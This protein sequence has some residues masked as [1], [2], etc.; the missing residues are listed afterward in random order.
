MVGGDGEIKRSENLV[1]LSITGDTRSEYGG[2][3]EKERERDRD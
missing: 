2:G 1:H 3:R